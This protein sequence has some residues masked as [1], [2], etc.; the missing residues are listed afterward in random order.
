MDIKETFL[1]LTSSTYPHGTEKMVLEKFPFKVENLKTDKHGNYFVKVGENSRTMFTS[2]LDTASSSKPRKV[3]HVIEGNII[4][5]D[6]T[7]IL[8]ADDKAGVTIMLYMIENK[9]PGTYFFFLGEERGCIGSSAA[10]NDK[11]WSEEFDRCISFDRRGYGSII[12]HQLG[13]YCCSKQFAEALSEMYTELGIPSRPDDTGIYTDSAQFIDRIKECT[14][15]SVGYRHEHTPS[16]FQ[17]IEYLERLA[18]ASLSVNW[19]ALPVV[20]PNNPTRKKYN[21]IEFEGEDQY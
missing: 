19:E 21:R 17:D 8:G 16:E 7:S 10:A 14:N 12:T 15:I 3:N 20:G 6:G 9:V 5:T 11:D 13:K 18:I 4:H 1:E 2:H